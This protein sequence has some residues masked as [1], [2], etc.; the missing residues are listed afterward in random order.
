MLH[1]A[2]KLNSK[3]IQKCNCFWV[4]SYDPPVR[5]RSQSSGYD[6][7]TATSIKRSLKNSRRIL[8]NHFAIIPSRHVTKKK[9]IYVGAE[10]GSRARVQTKMVEFIALPFPSSKKNLNLVFS[11]RSRAGTAKKFTKTRDA[12]ALLL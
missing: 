6:P 2:T 10:E 9:G 5:L 8:S 4:P 12:R 7:T 1:F 3:D 11:R